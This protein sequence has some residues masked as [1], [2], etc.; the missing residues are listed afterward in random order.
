[1]GQTIKALEL[2]RSIKATPTV[3]HDR[4]FNSL[5]EFAAAVV[6][7]ERDIAVDSRLVRAPAGANV[8][9]PSAGGFLVQ[10]DLVDGIIRSVYERSV[11]APWCDLRIT[12]NP[13][14]E[15]RIP[16]I[17]EAG[18]G[19]GQRN[20]GATAYFQPEGA[21]APKSVLKYKSVTFQPRK[22]IGI[23]KLTTDLLNDIPMLSAHLE[24][25]LGDEIGFQLD[26]AIL[27][28]T[29]AGV[30]TGILNLPALI[31]VAKE[32]GQA[33]GTLVKENID[34]LWARL[35]AAS[36]KRAVWLISEDLAPQLL[37]LNQAVGTG[38]MFTFQPP[39]AIP[40][41]PYASLYGRPIIETEQSP[42]LGTLGDIVLFDPSRYTVVS[43]PAS[44]TMSLHS[45]FDTDEATL[46]LVYYVDGRSTQTSALLPYQGSVTKSPFV[47]LAARP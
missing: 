17:D 36:R 6:R 10:H 46:K 4:G 21:T 22:L 47:T 20:G 11:V 1:M 27:L 14:R 28:G 30:P 13:I 40:G 34:K 33:A 24:D 15:T 25:V 26:R 39:G 23:C 16:G 41:S 9:D 43:A 18:R 38:G 45:G 5:G 31:T 32:T 37:A 29:G 35:P 7:A 19:D 42:T 44:F 2:I 12:A 3:R 8:N